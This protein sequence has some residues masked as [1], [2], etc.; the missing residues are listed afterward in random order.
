MCYFVHGTCSAAPGLFAG[1]PAAWMDCPLSHRMDCSLFNAGCFWL[2]SG[3]SV[4]GALTLCPWHYFKLWLESARAVWLHLGLDI[5]STSGVTVL[6][7][8][9]V[10]LAQ[11]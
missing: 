10:S 8:S 5:F 1:T 3:A 2:L 11:F 4:S 7:P 9:T 6:A